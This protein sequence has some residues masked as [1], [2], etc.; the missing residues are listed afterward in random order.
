MMGLTFHF[1]VEV[2][3]S[4]RKIIFILFGIIVIQFI[5]LALLPWPDHIDYHESDR[6][7]YYF[8]TDKNIK[9]AP[10]ISDSYYFSYD[11]PK[12]GLKERSSIIFLGGDIK[13]I[14]I[15]LEKLGYYV[16]DLGVVENNEREEYWFR[17]GG[18]DM[19]T[20]WYSSDDSTVI[21]TKVSS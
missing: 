2:S 15:Y 7:N 21:L 1:L 6:C 9:N 13:L 10:R 12:D 8:Y 20:L 18:G 16:S 17:T 3:V 19:F 4:L 5:I 11:A 14:K